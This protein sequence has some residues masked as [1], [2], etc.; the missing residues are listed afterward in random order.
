MVSKLVVIIY[1]TIISILHLQ[2]DAK[3][4]NAWL[5]TKYFKD[6]TTNSEPIILITYEDNNKNNF[7]FLKKQS[8]CTGHFKF[9]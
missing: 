9:V 4:K 1:I 5:N 3:M 6:T 7:F 8:T 2:L